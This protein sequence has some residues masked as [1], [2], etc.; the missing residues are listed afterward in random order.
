MLAEREAELAALKACEKTSVGGPRGVVEVLKEEGL[1]EYEQE[2]FAIVCL[3]T[4]LRPLKVEIIAKGT[5]SEV[6]VHPRD[7]FRA[8]VRTNAY[9]VILAHN[10]PSGDARPGGED[11][12]LTSRM[13]RAGN[14]LGIKVLDHIVVGRGGDW[15]TM[16]ES[17]VLDFP[18]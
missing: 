14:V 16:A 4:R 13:I 7:V 3:D 2:H 18:S 5:V 8:A 10:H 9:A 11:I 17:G 12:D 6:M 1:H 15:H